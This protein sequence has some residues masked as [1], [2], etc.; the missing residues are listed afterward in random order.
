[1]EDVRFGAAL[2]AARIRRGWRQIDLAKAAKVSPTVVS[3][4]ERGRTEEVGLAAIRAVAAVLGI[5]VELLP[6][7]R[8]GDL[9]R[10]L[11]AKHA[12]MA[13]AAIAWIQAF[14]GWTARPEVSFAWYGERGVVDIVAWHAATSTLLLIELKT[15]IVDIGELLGTMDRRHRLGVQI[16][17]ELGWKP[18]VVASLLLVAESDRNRRRVAAHS[19]TFA[20]A[21]PD[22]I[23]V[24]RRWLSVPAG[25]PR[26]LI[27]F[28]NNR[29][30]NAIQ[31]F[32][33]PSRVRR[34]KSA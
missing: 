7:S 27:F 20:S 3:R 19:T 12:G 9:D 14:A 18:A 8:A 32:G 16:A 24:V 28:A 10:L 6:R 11:N 29:Q 13:E 17:A 26:G 31:S 15:E 33:T 1:M 21:M 23:V 34:P 25:T 22:R 30:G 5:R 4:L 2:R